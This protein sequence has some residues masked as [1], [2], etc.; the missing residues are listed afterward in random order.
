MQRHWR[1]SFSP[2]LESIRENYLA[3]RGVK[4]DTHRSP[5]PESAD[6]PTRRCRPNGQRHTTTGG[7][8]DTAFVR[9]LW[10][11]GRTCRLMFLVEQSLGICFFRFRPL[12]CDFTRRKPHD[13]SQIAF[14]K[15]GLYGAILQGTSTDA[16]LEEVWRVPVLDAR[17]MGNDGFRILTSWN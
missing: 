7:N 16:T 14:A 8:A 5:I 3:G 1:R 10:D 11:S 2:R 9:R 15:K 4:R 17:M 6:R 12:G 13:Y